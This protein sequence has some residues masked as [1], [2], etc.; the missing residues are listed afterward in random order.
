[1]VS[2]N[3]NTEWDDYGS[4]AMRF[5]YPTYPVD[6]WD[7]SKMESVDR[8]TDSYWHMGNTYPV[9]LDPEV[10]VTSTYVSLPTNSAKEI[11]YINSKKY[12]QGIPETIQILL[13]STFDHNDKKYLIL[14]PISEWSELGLP[15][16]PSDRSEEIWLG[17]TLPLNQR[18]GGMNAVSRPVPVSQ[19]ESD[20]QVAI[21]SP[22]AIWLQERV[23]HDNV[24]GGVMDWW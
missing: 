21:D 12:P 4:P 11:M 1:V 20:L 7:Y 13:Y 14:G 16:P 24:V 9:A 18:S 22:M 23:P 6:Y 3:L 2:V 10:K 5:T 8:S 17:S 15:G 19:I